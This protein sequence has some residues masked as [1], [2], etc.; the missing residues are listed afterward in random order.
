MPAMSGSRPDEPLTDS[1]PDQ[2]PKADQKKPYA[3]PELRL[4]GDVVRDTRRG[5]GTVDGGRSPN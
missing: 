2:Q 5:F 4:Y 3:A 1:R